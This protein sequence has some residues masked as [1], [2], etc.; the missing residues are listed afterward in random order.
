MWLGVGIAATA[1]ALLGVALIASVGSL[2]GHSQELVEGLLMWSAA[3]I[4]TYVLWWMGKR[5]REHSSALRV[6]ARAALGAGSG[7]ALLGL[8]FLTVFRE[9]A[10]TVLYLSAT[11][12]GNSARGV[13]TGAGVGLIVGV[14][15][16]WA[17]YRGGTRILDLRLFFRATT[18]ILLVFA[19]GLVG[20][21]TL[22]LQAAHL[23][24][25]TIHA[26]DTSHL[27]AD[28]SPLGAAL[29]AL[30]GYTA[31]PSVL[32]LIFVASYGVLVLSLYRRPGAARFTPIG[33][34]Y[35]HPLYRAL[36]SGRIVR[37]LPAA[38]G[39]ALALLLA[40]ACP[41]RQR[42]PVR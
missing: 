34:D 13:A 39:L 14:F 23:F 35:G 7:L 42:R 3:A 19:A 20:R 31:R 12:A 8:V 5:A 27:L 36:R 15:G 41:A 17:I 16:G 1:S 29:S 40:V 25:G 32:Q 2:R 37:A 11:A 26:W 18:V 24:P 22:A 4:L 21:A 30:V 9:G 6:E 33:A 28:N 10:E 38:M